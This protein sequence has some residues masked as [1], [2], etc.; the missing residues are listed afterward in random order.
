MKTKDYTKFS[1]YFI[2]LTLTIKNKE[3]YL[4]TAELFALAIKL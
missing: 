1:K 3:V 2:Y 4:P